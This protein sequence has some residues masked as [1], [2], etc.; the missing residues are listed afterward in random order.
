MGLRR[1]T[2][3]GADI[4][5]DRLAIEAG[6][7][8]RTYRRRFAAALGTSP[9]A[10]AIACRIGH[11]RQMLG[12]TELPIKTIAQQLGYRDV[13][14]FSKQFARFAGISPAAYRRTKEA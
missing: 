13:F 14:F 8:P 3:L 1:I 12:T 4:D 11:A 7:S 10:Y 2:T 9:Q 6:M 5:Y